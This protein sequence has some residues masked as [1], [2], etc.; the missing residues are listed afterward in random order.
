MKRNAK[1]LKFKKTGLTLIELMVAV[2]IF[3]IVLT[4]VVSIFVTAAK[5]ERKAFVTQDLQDNA[6]FIMEMIIKEARMASEIKAGSNAGQLFI[7]NQDGNLV[8][9]RFQNFNLDRENQPLNSSQIKV[10]GE[11]SYGSLDQPRVT[12]MIRVYPA[13]DPSHPGIRIQNTVTIRKMD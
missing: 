10:E 12:V 11:F 1:I 7:I 2:A 4:I 3:L 5:N 8:N 9:Y 13:S 6:R